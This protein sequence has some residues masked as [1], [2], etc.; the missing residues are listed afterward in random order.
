MTAERGDTRVPGAG[1]T[2]MR[3]PAPLALDCSM[4]SLDSDDSDSGD[5]FHDLVAV[6]PI[7][8]APHISPSQEPGAV[9]E[10]S[11]HFHF[12]L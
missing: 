8:P 7:I 6:P 4:D 1:R 12:H 5:I 9:F 11:I 10:R 2:I 3:E